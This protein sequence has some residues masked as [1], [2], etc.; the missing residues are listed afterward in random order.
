MI[1]LY[2]AFVL[3]SFVLLT[4]SLAALAVERAQRT[5]KIAAPV[6]AVGFVF[7][8]GLLELSSEHR[9]HQLGYATAAD[10]R[11]AEQRAAQI[12]E[13][14]ERQEAEQRRAAEQA[15]LERRAAAAEQAAAEERGRREQ[16]ARYCDPPAR[17]VRNRSK[18]LLSGDNANGIDIARRQT[19]IRELYA[20]YQ[21]E[22]RALMTQPIANLNL[23]FGALSAPGT[24]ISLQLGLT[25]PDAIYRFIS[26]FTADQAVSKEALAALRRDSKV[27]VSGSVISAA[28][29]PFGE[30]WWS[31]SP[32]YIGIAISFLSVDGQVALRSERAGDDLRPELRRFAERVLASDQQQMSQAYEKLRH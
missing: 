30:A 11:D 31:I 1:D 21:D 16:E 13:A 10:W 6:F 25:C 12:K 3:L 20:A 14:G 15:A 8:V 17:Y 29:R 5:A 27:V 24:V 22:L 26:V 9:A 19:Q 28:Y 4:I 32:T 18:I 23:A 7:S 2:S